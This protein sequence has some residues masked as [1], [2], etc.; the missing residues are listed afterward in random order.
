MVVEREGGEG[1]Q[2]ATADQRQTEISDKRKS[3]NRCD[4]PAVSRTK[5]FQSPAMS[6]RKNLSRHDERQTSD[7]DNVGG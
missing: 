4:L 5:S 2:K 7:V 3:G 6:T 1:R